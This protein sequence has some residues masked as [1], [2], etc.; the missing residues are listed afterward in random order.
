M[1]HEATGKFSS[2]WVLP[3]RRSLAVVIGID[4][5]VE[6]GRPRARLEQRHTGRSREPHIWEIRGQNQCYLA[7]SAKHRARPELTRR[8][9]ASAF[10]SVRAEL[11]T[12]VGQHLAAGF[13][14]LR[15]ILLKA[16]QNDEVALVHQRSA[17]PRHVARARLLLIGRTATLLLG[18]GAGRDR[19]SQ[20]RK[21]KEKFS[22]CVPSS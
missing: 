19:Y 3:D 5:I 7:T 6:H 11:L 14:Q 8:G 18:N 21:R 16:R 1:I 13:R 2:R 9:P 4:C 15:T 22:H 12:V 17:K 20:Q 10:N